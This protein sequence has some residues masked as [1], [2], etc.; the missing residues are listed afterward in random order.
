M[1]ENTEIEKMTHSEAIE[2]INSIAT[3]IAAAILLKERTI[4]VAEIR[5]LPFVETDEQAMMVATNL[6]QLF[7]DV[8]IQQIKQKSGVSNWVNVLH[9]KKAPS[10]HLA[11]SK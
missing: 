1:K 2:T 5:A 7:D 9:L 3:R 10:T 8:E 6:T 11:P 4:S